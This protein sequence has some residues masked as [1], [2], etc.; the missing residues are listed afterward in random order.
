ML[1]VQESLGTSFGTLFRDESAKH[2]DADS[3]DNYVAMLRK[4]MEIGRFKQ[5]FL[6]SHQNNV[7]AAT[8][9]RIRCAGGRAEIEP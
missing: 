1:L 3:A 2:L 9:R 8:D 7:T 5:G 4:V 6:I